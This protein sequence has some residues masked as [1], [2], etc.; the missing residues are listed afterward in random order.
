MIAVSGGN[1]HRTATS[2]RKQR[3]WGCVAHDSDHE[4]AVAHDSDHEAAVRGR[5]AIMRRPSGSERRS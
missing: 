4:A 2:H 1:A 5:T 3:S